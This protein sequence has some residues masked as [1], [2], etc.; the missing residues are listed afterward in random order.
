[1]TL[2]FFPARGSGALGRFGCPFQFLAL[3]LAFECFVFVGSF[4]LR[5]LVAIIFDDKST[6]GVQRNYLVGVTLDDGGA[7]HAADHA[8]VLTLRDGH[9]TRRLDGSQTFRAIFS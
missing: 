9:S 4:N 3:V 6:H 1:M 8:G 7:R 5:T 2:S